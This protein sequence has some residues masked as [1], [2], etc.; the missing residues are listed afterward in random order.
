[1][2]GLGVPYR[3]EQHLTTLMARVRLIY[4]MVVRGAM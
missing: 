2:T 1:M 4:Y 3:L